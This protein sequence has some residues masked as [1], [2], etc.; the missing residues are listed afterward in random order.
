MS[1]SEEYLDK[2]ISAFRGRPPGELV[3]T[4]EFNLA[5]SC[6]SRKKGDQRDVAVSERVLAN[7][8]IDAFLSHKKNPDEEAIKRI[9]KALAQISRQ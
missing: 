2:M 3:T 7:A 8:T 9:R 6:V 4:V 1:R 5:S